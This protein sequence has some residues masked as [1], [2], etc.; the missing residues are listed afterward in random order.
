MK[1]QSSTFSLKVVAIFLFVALFTIAGLVLKK[2]NSDSVR[3]S[4]EPDA[5]VGERAEP[6][7]DPTTPV[8]RHSIEEQYGKLPIN[9]EP[10]VGQ[11]DERVRFLARGQGYSLFLS[12]R[13]ATLSLEKYGKSGKIEK[14]SAVRMELEGAN[15]NAKTN[16]DP[17]LPA[18]A[19][20]SNG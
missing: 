17:R 1:R 8:D 2:S 19:H 10:N 4:S 15:E 13:V 18:A 20:V 16:G 3:F 5:T 14:R 6:A 11:T 9:F 12:N 7:A